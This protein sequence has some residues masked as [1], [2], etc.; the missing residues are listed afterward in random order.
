MAA[1]IR[2]VIQKLTRTSNTVLRESLFHRVNGN[3]I[4]SVDYVGPTTEKF[5]QSYKFGRV[6]FYCAEPCKCLTH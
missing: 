1:V 4:N 5:I 6:Y 3:E 2:H